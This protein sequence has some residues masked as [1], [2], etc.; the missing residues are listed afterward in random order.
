MTPMSA[1][2]VSIGLCLLLGGGCGGAEVRPIGAPSVSSVASGSPIEKIA[3]PPVDEAL[4]PPAAKIARSEIEGVQSCGPFSTADLDTADRPLLE[5]RLRVRF[6][7]GAT[8][9]G[10]GASGKLESKRGDATVF[11]GARE[12]FQRGDE[13]FE[14]RAAKLATFGGQYD[15][16]GIDGKGAGVAITAGI[17]REPQGDGEMVALAHGWFIDPN[18]DVLDVAVFASRSALGDL[19][20]CRRFAEK[21]LSGVSMGPRRLEYGSKGEVVKQVSYAKF[22]F[23]LAADWAVTETMGIHD[24]ARVH[25]RRRGV[26]PSGFTEL[27]VAL[28][29]HPGDWASSGAATGDRQGK[30]LGLPVSW[31][32]TSKDTVRGA[33]TISSTVAGGDHAV[34]SLETSSERDR[35]EAIRFAESIQVGR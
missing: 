3:P 4:P 9:A 8:A 10:D 29:S 33:W 23:T 7:A 34:A 30:L 16:V 21:I 2:A 24:F 35:D 14:Q 5:D 11:F 27:Q 18:G 20:K 26:F 17:V 28:D 32:L 19:G 25:F 15:S 13:K 6:F 12:M 31:H 1:R 22:R